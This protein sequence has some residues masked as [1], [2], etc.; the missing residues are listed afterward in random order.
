MGEETVIKIVFPGLDTEKANSEAEDL[1]S[2]LKQSAE[3][4]GK[5][6]QSRSRVA[7]TSKEAMDFGATLVLVLG[8]PAM[9]I[10]ARAVKSWAERT[11]TIVE[12]DGVR[13]NNVRSQDL[14]A[15]VKELEK[16][17]SQAHQA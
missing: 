15:V 2:E 3:M 4:H 17:S 16:K 11:G 12:M 5:L 8:A 6:D 10:L 9:I 7:R 14:P 1:L 13:I